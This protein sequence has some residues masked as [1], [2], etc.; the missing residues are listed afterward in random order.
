MSGVHKKRAIVMKQL[1]GIVLALA[2]LGLVVLLVT[3]AILGSLI[4]NPSENEH[5]SLFIEDS[6]DP[7]C[8]MGITPG[9]S[10][11]E[12]VERIFN[13]LEQII[14]WDHNF[15]SNVINTQTGLVQDGQVNFYWR[16]YDAQGFGQTN[17]TVTIHAGIVSGIRVFI[18]R[19]IELD[20]VFYLMGQPDVIQLGSYTMATLDL[21]YMEPPMQIHFYAEDTC[22]V[23]RLATSFW[24]FDITYYSVEVAKSMFERGVY[25]STQE[26]NVPLE[27]WQAWLNREEGYGCLE[28]YN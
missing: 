13:N 22:T 12:D 28:A 19:R 4:V 9:V 6:C 1:Q 17:S 24:V 26:R 5:R 11:A 10:T 8:W 25:L 15:P 18:N 21:I 14:R 2:C 7:P 3:F 27:T 16:N 20:T 23:D